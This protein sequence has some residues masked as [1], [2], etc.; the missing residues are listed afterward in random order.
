MSRFQG[1]GVDPDFVDVLILGL[2]TGDSL[3]RYPPP[4]AG[5][6]SCAETSMFVGNWQVGPLLPVRIELTDDLAHK[7]IGKPAVQITD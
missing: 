4:P 7:A 2:R 5:D 3:E 6:R 1:F